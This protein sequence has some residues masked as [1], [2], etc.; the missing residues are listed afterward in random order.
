VES[1]GE[2]AAGC[3]EIVRSDAAPSYGLFGRADDLDRILALSSPVL[4]LTG[5]SGVGKSELL[6][7]AQDAT[8]LA[9]APPPIT[10][11]GTGGSLQRALLDRLAFATAELAKERGLAE[12]VGNR[13]IAAGKKLVA[14]GG[15]AAARV[16]A[17]AVLMQLRERIGVDA[18]DVV[19]EFVKDLG[20]ADHESLL[21]RINA[22]TDPDVADVILALAAEVA[23]VAGGEA[24]IVIALDG[25]EAL[26]ES[27]QRLLLDVAC[28][29]PDGVRLRVAYATY[30]E[31]RATEVEALL[32][33]GEAVQEYPVRA[34]S[35]GAI[36]DWLVSA[37]QDPE[38]A[39]TV[40]DRTDG[41]ALDV[42]DAIQYLVATGEIATGEPSQQFRARTLEAWR[43]LDVASQA[44][45]RK[46]VVFERPLPEEWLQSACGLTPAA[47]GAITERLIRARI[48]SSMV[49]DVPWFH[50]RRQRLILEEL[51]E[52]ERAQLQEAAEQAIAA[53][54]E[55]AR[56]AN[57]PAIT[58]SIAE[59]ATTQPAVLESDPGLQTVAGLTREQLS[60][61]AAL[62]ELYEPRGA[63]PPLAGNVMQHARDF[64]DGGQDLV[65][66][67]ME[68]IGLGLVLSEG[69]ER[70]GAVVIPTLDGDTA[71]ALVQGRALRELGRLPLPGLASSVFDMALRPRL[72]P[73]INVVYGL[74]PG[75]M[76]VHVEEASRLG[77]AHGL[78]FLF[79][80]QGHFLIIRARFHDRPLS[81]TI[82]FATSEDRGDAQARLEGLQLRVLGS[83]FE[84]TELVHHP[85]DAI[86]A[87]RF[88]GAIE[89]A[90]DQ[91]LDRTQQLDARA[92]L[93]YDPDAYMAAR[94][95]TFATIASLCSERER[96]TFGL[97]QVPSIHWHLYEGRVLTEG[98]VYGGEPHSVRHTDL[99]VIDDRFAFF[100]LVEAF[101]L[102]A[103]ERLLR[104]NSHGGAPFAGDPAVKV[105]EELRV[106][107]RHVTRHQARV[108]ID[109][110][111]TKLQAR[112]LASRNRE[113]RDASA[114]AANGLLS[115]RNLQMPQ[116]LATYVCVHRLDQPRG[117]GSSL[118][119]SCL[120][121]RSASGAEEVRVTEKAPPE[122][123]PD[124][125]LRSW[126]DLFGTNIA[127]AFQL[128]DGDATQGI[129]ALLGYHPDDIVLTG[130]DGRP[131]EAW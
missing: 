41:Y 52:S 115:V 77:H 96:S 16:V 99:P 4:V 92:D 14:D 85:D 94:V 61:A 76:R 47:W 129:A 81:A 131:A 98:E 37:G 72:E 48:L 34:L 109:V 89:R 114:L 91:R 56:T 105:I 103:E 42:G 35:V 69:G 46:L 31:Q 33:V 122:F 93:S 2:P 107:A 23:Q 62:L 65:P 10:V 40:L 113:L 19:A 28:G 83:T 15:K 9:T 63:F 74:G 60:V 68:L 50:P 120:V 71:P 36:S 118:T 5:D 84:I 67:L 78:P 27:D 57:D 24:P 79:R 3:P 30:T 106:K 82:R 127:G 87:D 12:Q 73:F 101:G 111:P 108:K 125:T 59:L 58:A 8:G 116:P 97:E 43:G 38:L 102:G 13:V 104:I 17:S 64:F 21:A 119:F 45:A 55:Y 95:K 53:Y 29:V 6:R 54:L 121:V 100:T 110:D 128:W 51:R 66:A 39:Q 123:R 1:P 117:F 75:T 80:G 25:V 26:P 124:D 22:A 88:V 126:G 130:P 7:A 11:R 32:A 20:E 90:L 70:R 112:I 18:V 86:A 49:N 44:I